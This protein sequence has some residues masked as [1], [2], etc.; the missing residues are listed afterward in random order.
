V[1]SALAGWRSR[2]L[3]WF[4]WSAWTVAGIAGFLLSTA[5]VELLDLIWIVLDQF[6]LAPPAGAFELAANASLGLSVSLP[7]YLIFRVVV[8]FRTGAA[9]AWVPVT[10]LV[11]VAADFISLLWLRGAPSAVSLTFSVLFGVA[12]VGGQGLLLADIFKWRWAPLLWL[13]CTVVF[14]AVVFLI[15]DPTRAL[16]AVGA[17]VAFVVEAVVLGAVYS[18]ITGAFLVLLARLAARSKAPEPAI[19]VSPPEHVEA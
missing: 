10:V 12:F 3:G 9:R 4:L 1:G 11:I 5:L 6:D 17:V 8:G 2:H 7:Q 14:V 15:P 13:L 18:A 19:G 16:E